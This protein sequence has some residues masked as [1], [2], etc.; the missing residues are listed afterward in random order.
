MSLRN[1]RN[2]NHSIKLPVK[3]CSYCEGK[4]YIL[5]KSYNVFGEETK[6]GNCWKCGG[7]GKMKTT[8]VFYGN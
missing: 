3:Q 5:I 2:K 6:K 8:K 7:S 1:H 4:G